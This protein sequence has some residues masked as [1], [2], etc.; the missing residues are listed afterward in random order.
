MSQCQTFG[1]RL[2]LMLF[3]SHLHLPDPELGMSVEAYVREAD[4]VGVVNMVTAGMDRASS[5]RS[6]DLAREHTPLVQTA[7][8][9]H[10][11]AVVNDPNIDTDA[12]KDLADKASGKFVAIGEVGLDGKYSTDQAVVRAQR[13]VFGKMLDLA[14]QHSVPVVVHSR[15]A[16]EAVLAELSQNDPHGVLLH[17]YSGP[18]D[19]IAE[20]ADRGY[21]VSI[22]PSVAY[23]K[24]IVDIAK[25]ASLEIL[26]TETDAPV[27]YY[28][29]FKGRTTSPRFVQEVVQHIARIKDL[30]EA[31]VSAQIERN[32]RRLFRIAP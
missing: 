22:G 10:P 27:E 6:L 16:T 14:E 21:L 20:I 9:I 26:L 24:R 4:D 11:W 23:S 15:V 1:A 28:G 3:D 13:D 5:E 8:G 12:M 18:T 25:L 17:W 30:S 29:Q 19:L 32:F 7:I 31:D 2:Q